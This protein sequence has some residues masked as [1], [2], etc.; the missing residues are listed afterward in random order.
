MV[1]ACRFDSLW[2]MSVETGLNTGNQSLFNNEAWRLHEGDGA[3]TDPIFRVHS[4]QN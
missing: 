4:C 2:L 3:S 1:L